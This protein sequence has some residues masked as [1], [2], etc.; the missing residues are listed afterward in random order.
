MVRILAYSHPVQTNWDHWVIS[1]RW[2]GHVVSRKRQRRRS[3]AGVAPVAGAEVARHVDLG[4]HW[5]WHEPYHG[6]GPA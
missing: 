5:E 2:T 6:K 3:G 1:Y 4:W